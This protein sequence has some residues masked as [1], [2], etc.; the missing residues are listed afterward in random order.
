MNEKPRRYTV[1]SLD[2]MCNDELPDDIDDELEVYPADEVDAI[3]A[4]V[5]KKKDC[6]LVEGSDGEW[7]CSACN[8]DFCFD[9]DGPKENHYAYCAFCGAKIIEY[10]DYKDL[11]DDEGGEGEEE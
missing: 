2:L 9:A 5:S 1:R 4:S 7:N 3:L 11:L 8:N 10:V 6:R